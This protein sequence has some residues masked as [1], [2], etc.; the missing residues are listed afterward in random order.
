MSIRKVSIKDIANEVG[1]S[2]A[3]VSFVMHN[4]ETNS[5]KYRVN[6]DTAKRILEAADRLGYMPDS[7]AR[8][9][10]CGRTNTIG[11]IVPD[12][13][14]KFFADIARCI[15]DH[16]HNYTVIFGSTDENA[17]KL[18]RLIDVFINKGVDGLI[19]VPCEN[20]DMSIK[21]VG[22]MKVP[23]VLLDREIEGSDFN[24]VVLNN[25]NASMQ[26][27]ETLISKGCRRIEMIS[28]SMRLSNIKE[29][30]AGFM[31]ALTDA[32]FQTDRVIHRV[33]H[34]HMDRVA[35]ILDGVKARGT[36]G[37]LFATNTFSLTGMK[38]MAKKGWRIPDDFHVATFDYSDAFE[39]NN[40]EISYI[41][42][43]IMQFST[44]AVDFLLKIIN[45]K[46]TYTA[47][48]RII[49]ASKLVVLP[50]V[51]DKVCDT[52]PEIK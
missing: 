13:S 11:V 48:T 52:R 36:D 18:D 49:L 25:F 40:L 28:Y 44:E 21:R 24:S 42:Q 38:A 39:I 23:M 51:P 34:E 15:E 22:E 32:G 16:A 2:I 46:N 7:S 3:L 19:I 41:Q 20:S 14:N 9:L 35:T 29:R 5:N 26:L 50:E 1:C 12:I 4:K 31:K 10:R 8:A 6:K 37:L 47:P 43:P 27:T 33:H 30:E 45:K 17:K